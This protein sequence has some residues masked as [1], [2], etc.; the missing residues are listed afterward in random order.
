MSAYLKG[1]LYLDKVA[2][3]ELVAKQRCAGVFLCSCTM[4][5]PLRVLWPGLRPFVQPRGS[6]LATHNGFTS[7]QQSST[8]SVRFFF[9]FFLSLFPQ[10]V[11]LKRN[12]LAIK[13]QNK[14][15]FQ[16]TQLGGKKFKPEAGNESSQPSLFLNSSLFSKPTVESF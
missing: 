10:Q 5:S 9:S 15:T 1:S 2:Q 16:G 3:G 8:L 6:I 12:N 4:W 7:F 14:S 11:P 13:F